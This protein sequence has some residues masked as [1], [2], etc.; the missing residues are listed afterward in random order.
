MT[1]GHG[2]S[3]ELRSRCYW[4]LGRYEEAAA[5]ARRMIEA[6]PDNFSFHLLY[7]RIL[8]MMKKM[9]EAE[10]KIADVEKL[11]PG[12]M[13]QVFIPEVSFFKVKFNWGK[14]AFTVPVFAT[15]P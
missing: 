12:N 1:F 11:D 7:A 13:I 14:S 15:G 4:R 3:F 6:E 5:D 10:R 9:A 8:T 2:R